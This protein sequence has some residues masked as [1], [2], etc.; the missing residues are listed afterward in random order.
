[1]DLS[2]LSGW[3]VV[4]EQRVAW[5]DMDS[6]GHVNNVVYFRYFE[7]S[8]LEYFRR[9]GWGGGERP[10][11]IGPILHSTQCRFRKPLTWPD[12]IAIGAR[13]PRIE[14]D[15]FTIEHLIV[16]EQ[17]G[18]AAEGWGLIVTFDYVANAKATVPDDLRRKIERMEGRAK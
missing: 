2:L 12:S 18:V 3:P 10:E 17:L 13:I 6:F 8:R 16:S 15:R 5:G 4:Y 11:G 9:L 1:M 7:N 14:A